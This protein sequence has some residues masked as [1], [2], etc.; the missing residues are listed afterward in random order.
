MTND[1]I[2]GIDQAFAQLGPFLT[3]LSAHAA[4]LDDPAKVAI[5][6]VWRAVDQTRSH[7][8]AIRDGRET[9]GE[10]KQQLAEL[11]SEAALAIMRV[12]PDFSTRLRMK[13]EYWTDPKTWRDEPG[14]DISIDTVARAARELLPSAVRDIPARRPRRRSTADIFISHASED[15]VAVAA[16]LAEALDRH[17]YGVW[18][19]QNEIGLGDSIRDRIDEALSACRYAAVILSAKVP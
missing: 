1:I 13:A 16:P 5:R 11:W 17:G 7:L 4:T 10:P 19:D 14:F 12:D 8:A 15:K 6:T 2:A 9:A 18:L 3:R